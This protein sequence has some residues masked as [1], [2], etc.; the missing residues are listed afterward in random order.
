MAL[1]LIVSIKTL[2]GK[3]DEY[4]AEALSHVKSVREEPGCGQYEYFR[5]AEDPDSFVLVERWTNEELWQTH[6]SVLR[7]RPPRSGPPITAGPPTLERYDV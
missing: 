3:G 1:R 6:M 2:P 5:A 7:A 4:I